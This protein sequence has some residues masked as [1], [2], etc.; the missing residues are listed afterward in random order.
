MF[1][2]F[3]FFI[4]LSYFFNAFSQEKEIASDKPISKEFS[5]IGVVDMRKIL[6]ESSSFL[7]ILFLCFLLMSSNCSTTP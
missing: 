5:K 7:V 1:K 2:I 3:V 6:Y 4:S